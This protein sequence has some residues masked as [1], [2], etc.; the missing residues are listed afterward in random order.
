M[1][2]T[3]LTLLTMLALYGYTRF[4]S[5]DYRRW[6]VIWIACGAAIMTKSAAALIIPVTITLTVAMD[7]QVLRTIQSVHFWTGGGS[8]STPGRPMAHSRMFLKYGQDYFF[9][10]T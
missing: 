4:E 6:Y 1:L 8:G 3:P 2:D 5:S 7:R 9:M 10:N